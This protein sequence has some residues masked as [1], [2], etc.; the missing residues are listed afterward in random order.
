MAETRFGII[1]CGSAALPVCQAIAQSSLARLVRVHDINAALARDLGERYR[2]PHT[3]NLDEVLNDSE[4]DAVYVAVPHHLLAALARQALHAGKHALV[5]K[6]MALTL[7][8]VDDLSAWAQDHDLTLGVFYEMR[9]APGF[10]AAREIVQ[11]GA[12]GSILGARIQTLIDKPMAYWQAGYSGRS[13]NGWR[14]ER[15][16]AGG[17][18][19]LMNTSH[20]FDALWYV[21]RLN[22]VRVAGEIGTLS[23]NVQVEDTAAAALRF[24]NGAVAVVF[25]GA[26]IA[27]AQRGDESFEIFGA[28]GALRVPDPYASDPLQIFLREPWRD[29]SANVWHTIPL[30]PTDVFRRAIDDFA[31]A[32]QE[33]ASAPIGA[34]D[35]RRVLQII[36]ALYRSA[37]EKCF[38]EISTE[39]ALYAH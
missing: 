3:T 12:L 2:V 15:A 4:I 21:T 9:Y 22:V 34:A 29:L 10:D 25:S 19:L 38:V 8:E 33:H 28:R 30:P 14:G 16:R 23:A 18:V 5:E 26:H 32:V 1:G 24:E 36:L 31:R 20:L 7:H 13:V 27:G 6:P 39:E 17:G 37:Q 11:A 35:A